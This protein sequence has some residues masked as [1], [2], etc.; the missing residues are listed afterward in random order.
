M[1]PDKDDPA[2]L[3]DMLDAARAAESFVTGKTIEDY[4]KERLLRSA[5]E[6]Q[7]EIIGEAAGRVS[8]GFQ[9]AHPEI[10]WR[11]IIAQRHVLA[12]GYGEIRH[13]LICARGYHPPPELIRVLAPLI[14]TTPGDN[15]E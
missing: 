3:W 7:I 9:D 14:P 5:V 4:A 12:H 13:D 10:P 2:W 8:Q 15:Q 11:P 6:R 1:L